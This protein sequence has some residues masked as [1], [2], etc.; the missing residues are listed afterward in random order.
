MLRKRGSLSSLY[1]AESESELERDEHHDGLGSHSEGARSD[2]SEAEMG[3]GSED[4]E[5]SIGTGQAS[6]VPS[7][8]SSTK[9]AFDDDKSQS[10]DI[11]CFAQKLVLE[12]AESLRKS[13]SAPSVAEVE[14]QPSNAI[15]RSASAMGVETASS[16][17]D[18]NEE[19][20]KLAAKKVLEY[21]AFRNDHC[22][23]AEM[24]DE[25]EHKNKKGYRIAI[26]TEQ[27]STTTT[28]T[29]ESTTTTSIS[30]IERGI[31]KSDHR[32]Q[33]LSLL[34]SEQDEPL[35]PIMEESD[36][37]RFKHPII[38]YQSS[39]ICCAR[40]SATQSKSSICRFKASTMVSATTMQ[41][42]VQNLSLSSQSLPTTT[43]T[44]PS[45]SHSPTTLLT[46]AQKKATVRRR[47]INNELAQLLPPPVD[48]SR[49]ND[50]DYEDNRLKGV[51]SFEARSEE[52][53]F[54][55]FI[56][57]QK[58]GFD[59]EDLKYLEK[60]FHD[61]QNDG[62]ANWNRI[63]LWVPP[64]E[65]PTVKLLVKIFICLQAKPR[66]VGKTEIFFDDPELNGVM[67]HSTGCARTQGYY[68]LSNKQ[69]RGIIRRPEGFQD[70]TEI[71]ERDE[72]TVR[73]VVQAT[74]EA[75]SDNRR[76]LT[77][78]GETSSDILKV[79]QLKYRKKMIKFARSRI[80]GWGLYALELIGPD[81]M[82]VEYVGQK[83]RPTVADEREK[84]YMRKGMGSSYLFRIDS[85]NVRPFFQ[86]NYFEHFSCIF[87]K[88]WL[89]ICSNMLSISAVVC[90][91]G[92]AK[93]LS[94]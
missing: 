92:S 3:S 74:R 77:S 10:L 68:K 52:Q 33:N 20:A 51:S 36:S 50:S 6:G 21:E 94:C 32:K 44:K 35:E 87:N 66:K 37:S 93:I 48:V 11:E 26:K 27:S 89:A 55:V 15:S 53:E 28:S 47:R 75:R 70:R 40:S 91:D 46:A 24:D 58:D 22:Y 73:H 59:R 19:A 9:T 54:D 86:L 79:N 31:G 5:G 57:Y 1:T 43:C 65:I 41:A 4:E 14:T 69:K 71:S 72:K 88:I 60:A 16:V 29:T 83:I 17:I 13:S 45:T 34:K 81:E 78:I 7:E 62:T 90:F 76:L 61:M 38:Q 2:A 56:K 63:L 25:D 12:E 49:L 64:C 85:D 67:P 80:H 84:K 39:A 23:F 18:D 42:Q 8:L 82:I 30:P